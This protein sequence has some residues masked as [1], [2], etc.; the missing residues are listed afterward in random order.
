M[1]ELIRDLRL[2]KYPGRG[3]LLG[4]HEDG[5]HAVI[6]YF[7][8]GRSEN[9]RNRVFVQE[10]DGL[11]TRAFD[12]SLMTDPSL[13]IYNPVRVFGK[14]TIVSNG[15]QTDTIYEY[16][17]NG[18]SFESALHTRTFE[19]D[20]PH[21]TP[22]ISGILERR[23]SK[24]DYRLS[25]LKSAEGKA[26]RRFFFEYPQP[27]AG[28][29]HLIHTYAPAQAGALPSFA[30]EPKEVAISGT[31]DSFTDLLWRSLNETNKVSLF[32]RF[33]NPRTGKIES[34]IVNKN[35]G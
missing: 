31:I 2:Q 34:R 28:R 30:G 29:G 26:V 33:L 5:L 14:V 25:I 3:I 16:I 32:V 23:G 19:P 22:R 12:P 18:N 1:T 15:D 17:E 13:V 27:I 4:C 9:S 10:G 24:F 35:R 6:A 20:A 8:M 7:I 11:R 21:Y